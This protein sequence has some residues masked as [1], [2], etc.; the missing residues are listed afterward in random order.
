[1]RTRW[2]GPGSGDAGSPAVGRPRPGRPPARLPAVGRGDGGAHGAIYRT[3]SSRPGAE[4]PARGPPQSHS[5]KQ[6]E[7][8]QKQRFGVSKKIGAGP[9]VRDE[10]LREQTPG[11]ARGPGHPGAGL[12]GG[13]WRH[14]ANPRAESPRGLEEAGPAGPEAG[15][16]PGR[17]GACAGGGAWGRAPGRRAH[18]RAAAPPAPR[19]EGLGVWSDCGRASGWAPGARRP[20]GWAWAGF[21]RNWVRSAPERQRLCGGRGEQES[22]SGS[23]RVSVRGARRTR[24][25]AAEPPGRSRGAGRWR[26]GRPQG[27]Q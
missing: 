10:E 20:G 21:L 24:G 17:G 1:M 11:P 23:P 4:G 12:R 7:T 8:K 2:G 9:G 5:E 15:S 14:A 18:S 26:A 13:A 27:S 16:C 3:G 6:N 19:P 25:A 22:K